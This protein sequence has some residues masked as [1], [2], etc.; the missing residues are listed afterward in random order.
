MSR[1]P[2]RSLRLGMRW[3]LLIAFSI[4]FS[5]V[6]FIVA[7]WITSFSTSTAQARLETQLVNL[8][9]G[10][11]ATMNVAGFT[12]L[13]AS[14]PQVI[15]G[16]RYPANA[17]TLAGSTATATSHYPTD[18]LYWLLCQQLAD[19]RRINPSA[20]PY[21]YYR[22]PDGTMK[23]VTSWG[24]LGYPRIGVDP[25]D[26]GQFLQPI[27][28]FVNKATSVYFAQGLTKTTIQP[29]YYDALGGWI[30]VYTPIKDQTGV[31]VGAI[32]VDYPLTYVSQVRNRVVHQ[33]YPAFGIAY[34]VLLLLVLGLSSQLTRRLGR[35]SLATKRVAEGE[36]DVDLENATK[37]VFADEMTDLAGSFMTMTSKV[38]TR[39]RTLA[40]QVENLKV[41]V[42]EKKRKE[43]VA[44][45]T[46]SDFFSDLTAK[47]D[48][49]RAK[50]RGDGDDG[51]GHRD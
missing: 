15:P 34:V 17:G 21:T 46:D 6:F 3:K 20:S 38:A 25:P 9:E 23:F 24:A 12:H 32:G 49:L 28:A 18:E 39:E 13:I 33:L 36:Y 19:I 42:D 29:A 43:A 14:D 44:E 1:S 27:S 26:G 11:A 30:S 50:V 2:R 16:E 35:L 7:W 22:A 5:L 4:G 40:R 47:A 31:T 51:D 37:A 41:E 8:S 45:I 48:Q 10:G